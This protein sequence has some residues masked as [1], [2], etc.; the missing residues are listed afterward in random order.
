MTLSGIKQRLWCW[1][2]YQYRRRGNNLFKDIR[3][4]LPNFKPQ[5]IF[6]IGANI[7]Q[8]AIEYKKYYPKSVIHSFEPAHKTF[9]LLTKNTQKLS[10]IN[11]HHLALSNHS[12]D[13]NLHTQGASVSFY[14][15]EEAGEHT[16]SVTV[17]TLDQFSAKQGITHIDFL[18]IDTEGADLA[19]L[20]GAKAMLADMEIDLIQVECTV[21]NV[22]T[23]HINF[24]MFQET[25]QAHGYL[26]YNFYLQ[27]PNWTTGEPYQ[28]RVNAVY[29]SEKLNQQN[30]TATPWTEDFSYE[31]KSR[32]L[33]GID[34]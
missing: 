24:S 9:Q 22:N 11:C 6:D 26:L 30:I 25:L 20:Q 10:N 28:R 23:R 2:L 4:E 7:G 34:N 27:K 15:T 3:A 18:K 21:N 31:K 16:E 5:I 17:T 1:Y 33:N 32:N 19:V 14:L 8:S 13:G 29:I 12:C